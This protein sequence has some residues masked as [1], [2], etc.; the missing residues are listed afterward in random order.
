MGPN[1]NGRALSLATKPDGSGSGG[2][3][4]WQKR[5]R[6]GIRLQSPMSPY[7]A[8]HF[9]DTIPGHINRGWGLEGERGQVC[10]LGM[11]LKL[12][13]KQVPGGRYKSWT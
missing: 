9:S 5:K 7:V 6:L 11:S 12:W 2:G 13:P 4:V 1:C 8:E 3:S 10:G